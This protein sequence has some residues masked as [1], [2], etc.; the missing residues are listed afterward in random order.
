MQFKPAKLDTTASIV[1]ICV[2]A[3]LIGLS[4]FFLIKVPLGWPFAIMMMLILLG[5]YLLS[6]KTYSFENTTL[7]IEKMIGKKIKIRF[8]DIEGYVRIPDFTKLKVA[9]TFGN[10]GLFGYYGMFTTAEYGTINCQLTS[11]K[12]IVIIK[13]KRGTFAVSPA[14]PNK[15]EEHFKNI[16]GGMTAEI[17][18]IEPTVIEKKKYAS[19]LILLIPI[20]LFVLT[21]IVVLLNYAQLPERI[22]VH[23]DFQGNP[24]RWGSKTSYLI[25]GIIPTLILL[26]I[27]IAAF[28]IVRRTTTNRALPNFLVIIVSFIQLFVAYTSFDTYWM[29]KHNSHVVPLHYSVGLFIIIMIVLIVYYYREVVKKSS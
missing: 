13:T 10:G 9:R 11:L 23:F 14:E 1:S 20:A 17:K 3:L 15:F 25:S 6:P 22:A 24:N 27:G 12:N 5:C 2:S 16:F 19:A 21:I 8:N 7:V 26:A 18:M 29:N 4:V 28:F